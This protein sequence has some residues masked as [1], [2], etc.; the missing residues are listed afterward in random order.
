MHNINISQ[1]S[2]SDETSVSNNAQKSFLSQISQNLSEGG[3][4]DQ[5]LFNSDAEN[6]CM[7][8]EYKM[9]DIKHPSSCL[10]VRKAKTKNSSEKKRI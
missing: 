2:F 5:N 10:I 7:P 9:N 4:I 1:N 8:N 3:K 6:I